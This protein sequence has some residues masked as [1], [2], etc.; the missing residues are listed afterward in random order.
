[1]TSNPISA[2]GAAAS[3]IPRQITSQRASR[4]AESGIREMPRLALRYGA[5]N[6]SQGFADF[7]APAEVKDAAKR[8]IDADVNQYA[9]TWGAKSFRDALARKASK[10]LGWDVDPQTEI[11]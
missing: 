6:L 8:A 10:T 4:L 3:A 2:G 1:M 5:V 11:T 9:I 7:P